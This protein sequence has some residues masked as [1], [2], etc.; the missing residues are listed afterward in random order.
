MPIR[1]ALRHL[2]VVGAIALVLG[3]ASAACG[4]DDGASP[5]TS[6]TSEVVKRTTTDSESS[7]G[8][9]V[10][11][12]DTSD[13]RPA[14]TATTETTTTE[15]T[16]TTTAG[17]TVTTTTAAATTTTEP[18]V[19]TTLVNVYWGWTV[20]NPAAG[21][22][23][24]IGAG[25]RDVAAD[26]P[27]RNAL[28]A[29]FAGVDAVEREIGMVSSIPEG[30]RVLGI[31]VDGTTATVDLSA[32]FERPGGTLDESM[33]LA[34]VVFAVTQF[35]RFDRVKFH[36]A[37]EPRQTILSHGFEVGD[38]LTRDDFPDV[39]ARIMIEDPYPGADVT[40]PLVIAGESNTFEATVRYAITS[41][42]GDGLVLTEGFTTATGGMGTWGTFEIEVDLAALAPDDIAGPGSIVLWEDSPRSGDRVDVVEIPVVL[43]SL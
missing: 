22:P 13:N 42:G 1:P 27:V 5:A 14:S 39:R 6:A 29:M 31:A 19:D 33:R 3:T 20:L 10:E 7:P 23:E 16:T 8:T 26:T 21:S 43:P 30:T 12:P 28:K 32:E 18:T 40:N 17:D 35:D 4:D 38:G 15:G 41:G 9:T 37:G 34:Q 2:A 36:V 11:L 24:R 25:A